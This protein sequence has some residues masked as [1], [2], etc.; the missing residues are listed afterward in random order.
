VSGYVRNV[1]V[2]IFEPEIESE[3]STVFSNNVMSGINFYLNQHDDIGLVAMIARDTG[4]LIQKHYTREMATHTQ[5][6][7]LVL[8]DDKSDF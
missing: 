3:R 2:S 1:L 6:P 7:L 5:Y 4:Q 8:Y